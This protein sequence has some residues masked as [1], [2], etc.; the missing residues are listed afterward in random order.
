[1]SFCDSHKFE[2]GDDGIVRHVRE[3]VS[4]ADRLLDGV[5]L[6]TTLFLDYGRPAYYISSDEKE[7]VVGDRVVDDTI[8]EATKTRGK[9]TDKGDGKFYRS[10]K[11]SK[12]HKKYAT[13]PKRAWDKR[14]SKVAQELS[15]PPLYIH[16]S[17]IDR[18]WIEIEEAIELQREAWCRWMNVRVE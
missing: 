17:D 6:D 13:K 16:Q 1:M 10:R 5:S 15:I 7:E 4:Y 9:H 11:I 3:G 2:I 12:K 8:Q 14:L 18:E